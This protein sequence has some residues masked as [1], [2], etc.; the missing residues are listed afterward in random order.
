[1]PQRKQARRSAELKRTFPAVPKQ[2]DHA[3]EEVLQWLQTTRCVCGDLDEIRAALR[4][5]LNNALHHGCRLDPNKRVHLLCRCHPEAGLELVLRD[6]G[7]G[8]DPNQ[9]PDPTS[10]EN[11]ERFSGRGLYMIRQLMDEV[12]FGDG[13]REIRMR[14]RPRR[15]SNRSASAESR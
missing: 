8:F 14:R 12:K 2:A 13:G 9:I 10:A 1:M 15:E 7:E 5:A 11:L 6:E 4:E 3:L